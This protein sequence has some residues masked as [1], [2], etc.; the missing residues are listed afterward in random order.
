M[1]MS[2]AAVAHEYPSCTVA[3]FANR[4]FVAFAIA[5]GAFAPVVSL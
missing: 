2:V 5:N 3:C 4:T 1:L